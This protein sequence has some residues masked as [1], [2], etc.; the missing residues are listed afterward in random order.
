MKTP[1]RSKTLWFNGAAAALVAAEANLHLLQP[2]LGA[3]VYVWAAF[4]VA[5]GNTALRAVTKEP[6]GSD[7]LG[8]VSTAVKAV[9]L[10]RRIRK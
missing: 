3:D 10:L 8:K 5:A 6:L 7:K 4:I 1:L 2:A 9:D